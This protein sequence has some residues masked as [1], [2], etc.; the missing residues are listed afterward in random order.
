VLIWQ[1][2]ALAGEVISAVRTV[3]ISKGTTGDGTDWSRDDSSGDGS[4]GG[5]LHGRAAGGTAGERQD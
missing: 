1:V 5:A 4:Y 3:G 2:S